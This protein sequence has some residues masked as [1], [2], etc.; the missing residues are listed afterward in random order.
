MLFIKSLIEKKIIVNSF[1][2]SL[3]II[4]FCIILLPVI[5]ALNSCTDAFGT[6]P[7]V[8][9]TLLDEEE[10]IDSAKTG[11]YETIP[12]WEFYEKYLD[13]NDGRSY[14]WGENQKIIKNIGYCD[15]SNTDLAFWLDTQIENTLPDSFAVNRHDRITGFRILAD[16]LVISPNQNTFINLSKSNVLVEVFIKDLKANNKIVL[17]Q[18]DVSMI[19]VVKYDFKLKE[20]VGLISVDLIP[21]YK[22]ETFNF[23]AQFLIKIE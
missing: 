14:E 1:Y 22:T 5:Y 10:I 16:S 20:L 11:K 7:N 6:D 19:F 15:T 17:N 23:Q 2:H 4:L 21:F 3:K 18:K 13:F 8:K 9:I 12:S